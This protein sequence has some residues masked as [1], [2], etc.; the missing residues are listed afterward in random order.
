M[1]LLREPNVPAPRVFHPD[2]IRVAEKHTKHP[3][4]NIAA[5]ILQQG[6]SV[7][8]NPKSPFQLAG[9]PLVR[10]SP[11]GAA[12]QSAERLHSA[13][14]PPDAPVPLRPQPTLKPGESVYRYEGMLSDGRETE[15]YKPPEGGG[16]M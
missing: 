13:L 2:S 3:I 7:P 15:T 9:P 8:H 12:M 16:F 5:D 11:S 1:K 10:R 14:T 4:E 6:K